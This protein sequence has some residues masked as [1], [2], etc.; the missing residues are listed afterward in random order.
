MRFPMFHAGILVHNLNG[1]KNDHRK[2]LVEKTFE[3]S[4]KIE[5]DHQII[6][7]DG[8]IYHD[9]RWVKLPMN[10]PYDWGNN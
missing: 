3:A 2:S 7:K 4:R 5:K 6:E 1:K 8:R 9:W 10:I